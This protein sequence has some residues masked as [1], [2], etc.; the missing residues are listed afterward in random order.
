M[1]AAAGGSDVA[2]AQPGGAFGGDEKGQAPG[3]RRPRPDLRSRNAKYVNGLPGIITL[4]ERGIPRRF[5]P[6]PRAA[7]TAHSPNRS[8][9]AGS[10]TRALT[11]SRG[12]EHQTRQAF[13]VG[14]FSVRTIS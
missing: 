2:A 3:Y 5:Y 12:H 8:K 13:G 6:A 4:W 10:D 1:A 11:A 14:N 9:H 7:E